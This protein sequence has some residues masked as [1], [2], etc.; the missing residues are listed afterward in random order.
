MDDR[1]IVQHPSP[2]S[3]QLVHCGD[4]ALWTTPEKAKSQST[5]QPA[6]EK[7]QRN[8]RLVAILRDATTL[9]L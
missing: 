7:L 4:Y 6:T 3:H 5:Q 2:Q 1:R 9:V 8:R